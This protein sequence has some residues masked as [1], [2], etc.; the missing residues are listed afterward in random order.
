MKYVKWFF[1]LLPFI[2][3]LLGEKVPCCESFLPAPKNKFI[4]FTEEVLKRLKQP[5]K[6]VFSVC[7]KFAYAEAVPDD[8]KYCRCRF[9]PSH[10]FLLTS[11]PSKIGGACPTHEI[12]PCNLF[13]YAEGVPGN[14]E[15]CRC[16]FEP[17]HRFL[18]TNDEDMIGGACPA[19]KVHLCD[20]FLYAETVPGNQEYC[21]CR[22]EPSHRF[23]VTNDPS[24]IGGN[25]PNHIQKN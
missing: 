6:V 13:A 17:S 19:P 25:C 14:K 8:Q 7:R 23:L 9:E 10:R 22:F 24:E 2:L 20:K 15:Y 3:V 18:V 16:R 11:D 5:S 1:Y 12:S 4:N 21:R